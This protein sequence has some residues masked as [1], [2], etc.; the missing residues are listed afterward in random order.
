MSRHAGRQVSKT[1]DGSASGSHRKR[2]ARRGASI[3]Q[4][5]GDKLRALYAEAEQEPLPEDL[6]SL[7]EMLDKAEGV[8]VGK[9]EEETRDV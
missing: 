4:E 8:A 6:I 1:H 9:P 7:L 5:I 2:T 3:H